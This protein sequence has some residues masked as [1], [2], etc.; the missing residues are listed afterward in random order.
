[1]THAINAL[2]SVASIDQK[3]RDGIKKLDNSS[4]IY[5]VA[6]TVA[7]IAIAPFYILTKIFVDVVMYLCGSKNEERV[8]DANE[9]LSVKKQPHEV[10][11]QAQR[12]SLRRMD[13]LK[14]E[15]EQNPKAFSP[16]ENN[17]L[18]SQLIKTAR[19]AESVGVASNVVTNKFEAIMALLPQ[20]K[21]GEC[22]KAYSELLS[23]KNDEADNADGDEICLGSRSDVYLQRICEKVLSK[24]G[25]ASKSNTIQT[26]PFAEKVALTDESGD[27]VMSRGKERFRK[28]TD[29]EIIERILNAAQHPNGNYYATQRGTWFKGPKV[30]QISGESGNNRSE[31]SEKL[32]VLMGQIREA[33]TLP[34]DEVKT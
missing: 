10:I 1:M 29:Q 21:Q 26:S 2:P 28:A 34:K 33:Y 18:W 5:N 6:L 30:V 14:E 7:K 16:S 3:N 15:V 31:P 22:V 23:I 11:Q 19:D 17:D 32:K 4:T 20:K 24:S 25:R 9:F 13:N 12:E 27:P 8:I